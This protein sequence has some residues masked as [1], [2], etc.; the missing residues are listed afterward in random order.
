M[1]VPLFRG[2]LNEPVG[3]AIGPNDMNV[4]VCDVANQ[5]VAAFTQEGRLVR[6]FS[7]LGWNAKESGT[8]PWIEPYVAVSEDG[9]V[10]ITDSTNG[11]I[12]CF[13]PTGTNVIQYGGSANQGALNKPK[14]ITVDREGY[15]YIADSFNHRVVKAQILR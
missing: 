1:P 15:L 4:Y 10:Y 5:R 11:M 9:F 7:I 3:L 6:S 14:G 13:N 8:V 12:H 2:A